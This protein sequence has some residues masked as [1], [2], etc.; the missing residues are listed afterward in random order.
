MFMEGSAADIEAEA[1]NLLRLFH[2]RGGFILS[3][4]CEIPP[5]SLEEN[6]A[7]LINAVR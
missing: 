7:A 5:E 6:V 1:K 2:G 3:S 4:G